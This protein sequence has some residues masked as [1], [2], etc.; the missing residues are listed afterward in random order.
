MASVAAALIALLGIIIAGFLSTIVAEDY[1]RF[2]DGSGLA[3]ALAGELA[4]YM[5]AAEIM[6][7]IMDGLQQAAV[8]TGGVPLPPLELH[9]QADPAFDTGVGKLGLLGTELAED[10]AFVYQQLR[11]FRSVYKLLSTP[12]LQLGPTQTL[13]ILAGWKGT[14]ERARTRGK[15]LVLSLKSRADR[16]Y[17]AP[18]PLSWIQRLHRAANRQGE[19]N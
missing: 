5:L 10:T 18:W 2:R 15:P 13:A 3:A 4:S 11:A 9:S 8:A 17:V 16:R 7:P 1:R 6:L 19:T 12:N 14:L